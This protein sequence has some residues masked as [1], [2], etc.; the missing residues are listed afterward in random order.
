MRVFAAFEQANGSTTRKYGGTSL[1]LT[2]SRRLTEMM[3]GRIWVESEAGRRTTFPFT[4]GLPAAVAGPR[5]LLADHN[6]ITAPGN[7]IPIIARFA[8]RPA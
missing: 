7:R 8:S 2:I 4:L 3:G 1:D 6:R 5:I